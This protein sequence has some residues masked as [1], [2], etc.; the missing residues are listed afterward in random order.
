MRKPV[1]P[2]HALVFDVLEVQPLPI[3]APRVWD[4]GAAWPPELPDAQKL[5]QLFRGEVLRPARPHATAGAAHLSRR[6][7]GL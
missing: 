3:L 1:L 4:E 6:G 5:L 2:R 7:R